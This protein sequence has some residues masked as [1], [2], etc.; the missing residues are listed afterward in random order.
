MKNTILIFLSLLSV[1]FGGN[2]I[3]KSSY[4]FNNFDSLKTFQINVLY[5]QG[6]FLA[7]F[8]DGNQ[9]SEVAS[10]NEFSFLFNR[11]F[12]K[13]FGYGVQIGGVYNKESGSGYCYQYTTTV[14]QKSKVIYSSANIY[15]NWKYF[16][17]KFKLLAYD[18]E[19]AFCDEAGY[20]FS[21]L[22]TIN[23]KIGLVNRIYITYSNFEDALLYP[24]SIGLKYHFDNY[25][26]QFWFGKI[27]GE[28]D[29][30]YSIKIELLIFR[31][32]LFITQGFTYKSRDKKA[33][34]IGLGYILGKVR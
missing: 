11:D 22:P 18:K 32:I 15:F 5:G 34:R 9:I 28:N 1:V 20:G 33:I 13:R 8:R 31:K 7:G 10:Y 30:G 21:L 16:G 26:S 19:R 25:F 23:L 29:E 6:N 27:I 24:E 4:W 14:N 12:Y 17:F 3:T 2:K